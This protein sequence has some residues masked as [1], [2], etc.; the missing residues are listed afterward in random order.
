MSFCNSLAD[1]RSIMGFGVIAAITFI[2]VALAHD[3]SA[4]LVNEANI[5]NTNPHI[6]Y[7]AT[8]GNRC[9]RPTREFRTAIPDA[10]CLD[11]EGFANRRNGDGH[12][13]RYY[14][15]Q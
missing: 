10:I 2:V 11:G 5:T 12:E 15:R 14:H 13:W 8:N 1:R 6:I 3:A 7:V 4:Q 9:H